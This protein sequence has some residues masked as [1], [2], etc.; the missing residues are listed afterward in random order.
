MKTI[1]VKGEV[2]AYRLHTK[3]NEKFIDFRCGRFWS[4]DTGNSQTDWDMQKVVFLDDA[5]KG[6]DVIGKCCDYQAFLG[7]YDTA[8]AALGDNGMRLYW[9]EKLME[10]GYK[11]PAIIHPSAVVSPSAEIGNG[12]L[13]CSVQ[14]LIHIQ[15]LSMVFL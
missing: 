7:E 10:A 13:L 15:S 2:E 9:T 6:E 11:V 4:D 1:F 12:S 14:L 3:T 5:A 8:V